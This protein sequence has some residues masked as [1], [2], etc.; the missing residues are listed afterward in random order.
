VV[1]QSRNEQRANLRKRLEPLL[2][3]PLS[4][5]QVAKQA[6]TSATTV[7]RFRKQRGIFPDVVRGGDGKDYAVGGNEA[8]ISLEIRRHLKAVAELTTPERATP[9]IR[10]LIERLLGCLT[11]AITT[12]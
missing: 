6:G 12:R 11:K 3:L 10:E 7:A 9:E 1:K 8:R 4:N 5:N 2:S